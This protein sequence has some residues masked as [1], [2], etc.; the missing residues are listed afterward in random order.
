MSIKLQILVIFTKSL[1]DLTGIHY[2]SLKFQH[3]YWTYTIDV[4]LSV[5]LQ[6]ATGFCQFKYVHT[7]VKILL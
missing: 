3:L 1:H 7:D 4:Y 5:I 2:F 6:P